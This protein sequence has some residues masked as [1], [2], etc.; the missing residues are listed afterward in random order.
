MRRRSMRTLVNLVWVPTHGGGA[1]LPFFFFF[2]SLFWRTRTVIEMLGSDWG[3][4]DGLIS[5]AY[6]SA[7]GFPSFR[8]LPVFTSR[9]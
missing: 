1:T 6:D 8:I 2:F 7:G 9:T 4:E 5:D 3:Y